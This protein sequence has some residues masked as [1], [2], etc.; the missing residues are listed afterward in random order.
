MRLSG[1]D[2]GRGGGSGGD[3]ASTRAAA[4][5]NGAVQSLWVDIGANDYWPSRANE[6]HPHRDLH[7]LLRLSDDA[8]VEEGADAQSSLQVLPTPPFRGK[9]ERERGECVCVGPP[10]STTRHSY[11]LDM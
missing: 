7:E 6:R 11:R 1:N 2:D 3:G 10:P 4:T 8:D 5:D 9:R